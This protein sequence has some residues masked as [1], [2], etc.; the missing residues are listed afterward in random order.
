MDILYRKI[1]DLDELIELNDVNNLTY[2]HFRVYTKNMNFTDDLVNIMSVDYELCKKI[3]DYYKKLVIK[4]SNSF[5]L[6]QLKNY[7]KN[8]IKFDKDNLTDEKI[9]LVEFSNIIYNYLDNEKLIDE[10]YNQNCSYIDINEEIEEIK[11]DEFVPRQNQQEAFDRLENNGLET[12]IHCQATG[13]GK[14][15]IILKYIDYC[16]RIKNDCKIILFTERVSI[17]K[18]LLDF[19][20]NNINQN[21]LLKWKQLG[22]CDLTE[23]N[24]INRVTIKNKDWINLLLNEEGPLL[25]VI[26]R[27]YLTNDELYKELDNN[28]L[29]LVL[30]DECHN[31]T[32]L[33]C[34]NF[35]KHCKSYDIKIVG[36][37]ATPLRTGK[38]DKTKL[39]EIYGDENNNLILL[40]NYNM[41][42]SIKNN[43]ILPPVFYWF[44]FDNNL[45]KNI[46]NVNKEVVKE[47]TDIELGSIFRILNSAYEKMPNRKIIA[48]C[49]RIDLAEKWKLKMENNYGQHLGFDDMRYYLDTSKNTDDDYNEFKNIESD[50]ILFC[51]NKHREGSD[52]KNLDCCI[53]LDGVRNRGTIPLIQSVGRV[54]RM[55]DNKNCGVII[56]GTYKTKNHGYD[57]IVDKILSY[58]FSLQNLTYGEDGEEET[59]YQKYLLIKQ[60]V[61]LDK[62]NNKISM[63][64]DDKEIDIYID[65]CD[66]S[67]LS[68]DFDNTL[69]KRIRL[70]TS[71]HFRSKAKILVEDY[72]FNIE[73]DFYNEYMNIDEE[74]KIYHNF[75]DIEENDFSNLFSNDTWFDYL[76][77]EHNYYK[78]PEKA[79][80]AL[81]KLDLFKL[82]NVEQ[83][84]ETFRQFLPRLPKYPHYLW[85]DFEWSNL[86]VIKES[87]DDNNFL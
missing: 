30:H 3:I 51:A 74:E 33:N 55:D 71:E 20:D 18:D 44:H 25:L 10:L 27:A 80:K 85:K 49:R 26:N 63:L 24:I 31:T 12:G 87:D 16:K 75:P 50:A 56:E 32:S 17:L 39:C 35:L 64:I 77:L 67:K 48:W 40:T 21:K 2:K 70:S 83:N 69:K 4:K 61:R 78:T 60:L 45:T 38:H 11:F 84:Y 23:F 29:D 82:E 15:F 22:I 1:Q 58:Y 13:C 66:W 43:L 9:K 37:S 68:Y 54:L 59:K 46:M 81:I 28:T 65:T 34:H 52:I 86:E 79:L 6:I 19:N 62:D 73:T 14:T 7:L 72:E 41:I 36:F 76:E 57:E 47:I 8:K 42:Y 53:F 5:D